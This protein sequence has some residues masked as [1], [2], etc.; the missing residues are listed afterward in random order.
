M[1]LPGAGSVP[2]NALAH[3]WKSL[4][5]VG[6][7]SA[8]SVLAVMEDYLVNTPGKPG[9]YSILAAMGPAFCSELVLLQW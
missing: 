4:R 7:L 6:N 2:P 5:E 1:A 9:T 8:A 3:S